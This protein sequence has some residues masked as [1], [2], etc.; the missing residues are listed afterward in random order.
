MAE[1]R[2]RHP[3]GRVASHIATVGEATACTRAGSHAGDRHRAGAQ[4]SNP[5]RLP[6]QSLDDRIREVIERQINDRIMFA[7][8]IGMLTIFEWARWAFDIRLHPLI[9]TMAF[10]IIAVAIVPGIV[11]TRKQVRAMRLGRDGERAVG[12]AL[13]QLRRHGYR[14]FHDILGPSW[15]IDHV[16][17]GP[18]GVF[19]VETKTLSKPLRGRAVIRHEGRT[20]KKGPFDLSNCLDQARAQAAYVDAWLKDATGLRYSVQP[21]LVFPGWSVDSCD[22]DL[23]VWVMDPKELIKRVQARD[24]QFSPAQIKSAASALSTEIRSTYVAM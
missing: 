16:V 13:E 14:V 1:E 15:N 24:T 6:G 22:A 11:R 17:I 4:P 5:L 12:Q 3:Q 23:E 9:L 20:L 19:T 10:I 2:L 18:G 8:I 21:T 7:G